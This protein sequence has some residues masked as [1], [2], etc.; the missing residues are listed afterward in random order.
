MDL[1]TDPIDNTLSS[2]QSNLQSAHQSKNSLYN[3]IIPLAIIAFIGYTFYKSDF[4]LD[5]FTGKSHECL[6][7]MKQPELIYDDRVDW[8]FATGNYA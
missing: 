5:F 3:Y 6:K 7:K 1:L 2:D 4:K 8:L